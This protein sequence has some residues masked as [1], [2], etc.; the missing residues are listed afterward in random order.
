[1]RLAVLSGSVLSALLALVVLA[2]TPRT[3]LPP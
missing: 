3:P 1:V 2:L